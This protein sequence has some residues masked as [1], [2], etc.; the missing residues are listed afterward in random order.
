MPRKP[1]ASKTTAPKPIGTRITP[2][3]TVFALL[4]FE[5]PDGYSLAGGLGT[6]MRELSESLAEQGYETHLYF[7]GDPKLPAEEVRVDG[8]LTLHRWCQ[9]LSKIHTMGVYDG[10]DAK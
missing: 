6:R 7:V 9:W 10:E 1:A 4:S 5:G 3:N 8:K 2:E